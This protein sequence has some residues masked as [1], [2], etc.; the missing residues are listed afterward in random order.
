M[1][2]CEAM[3]GCTHVRSKHESLSLLVR[4]SVRGCMFIVFVSG[5]SRRC[6]GLESS[7]PTQVPS[8]AG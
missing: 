4:L 1:F 3:K 8:Q 2:V 6:R 7:C 5:S